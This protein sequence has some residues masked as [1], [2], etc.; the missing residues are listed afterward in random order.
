[1]KQLRLIHPKR[2][3]YRFQ[4]G[5]IENQAERAYDVLVDLVFVEFIGSVFAGKEA[6]VPLAVV[7]NILGHA[8]IISYQFE[9]K[10]LKLKDFKA[11]FM[12][13]ETHS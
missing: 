7:K 11:V 13:H 6:G 10:G 4:Y 2:L 1:M 9:T 3:E 5:R 8:S 12:R